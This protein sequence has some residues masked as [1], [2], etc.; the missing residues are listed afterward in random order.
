MILLYQC[1]VGQMQV[2]D[3]PVE[4]AGEGGQTREREGQGRRR[5][6]GRGSSQESEEGGREDDNDE[7]TTKDS[8]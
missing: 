3:V 2:D 5:P 7:V 1:A 6:V 4:Y 8:T